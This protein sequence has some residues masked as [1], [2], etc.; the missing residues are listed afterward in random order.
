MGIKT[1]R[2]TKFKPEYCKM[3]IDHMA[4]GMSYESFAATCD[5]HRDT[6][7]NWEKVHK[8][9]L[10][11]KREGNEKR[12][13]FYEKLGFEGMTGKH[14]KFSAAMWIFYMKNVHKWTDR[15]EVKAQNTNIETKVDLKNL[16]ESELKNLNKILE[17]TTPINESGTDAQSE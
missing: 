7:Y 17:K 12:L 10:D 16:S 1:G 14:E 6:L 8:E 11:A 3:L 13:A 15:Q 9:F 2:P 4:Q 5:T